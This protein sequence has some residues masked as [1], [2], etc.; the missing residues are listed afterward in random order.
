MSAVRTM[1]YNDYK[2]SEQEKIYLLNYCRNEKADRNIIIACAEDTNNQISDFL[3]RSVTAKK[4]YEHLGYVPIS[5]GDFYAYRRKMLYLLKMR[6]ID[7][8]TLVIIGGNIWS[9]F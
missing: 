7:N 3:F 4:S 9:W 6:L 2:V 5:K 1:S 8:G